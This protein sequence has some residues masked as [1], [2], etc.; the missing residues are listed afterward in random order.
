VAIGLARRC[1]R[2]RGVDD[3]Q[4][5]DHQGGADEQDGRADARARGRALT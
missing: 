2:G 3:R 1:L 5:R 4:A